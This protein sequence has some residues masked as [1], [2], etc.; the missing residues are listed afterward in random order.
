M[1]KRANG[2]GTKIT[3][4]ENGKW[5]QRVTLS[6]GTRKAFYGETQAEVRQKRDEF[7]DAFRAGRISTDAAQ[8]VGKYLRDWLKTHKRIKRSTRDDY[9][10]QIT[11]SESI[12]KVRLDQVKPAHLQALYDELEE[13]GLSASSIDHVH[14]VLRIAFRRAVKLG[15]IL[16]PPTEIATPPR[17]QSVERPTLSAEQAR[18]LLTSDPQHRL[19]AL[20][21]LFL[22]QGLRSGEALGLRWS[23][24]DF[25]A[26]RVSIRHTIK[27]LKG[28]GLVPETPKT[29][30]SRRTLTLLPATSAVLRARRIRQAEEQLKA[31]Q[32]ESS[33]EWADLVF[34]T[35]T[36]RPLDSSDIGRVLHRALRNAGLPLIRVHDLRHT[37]A[38]LLC[39]DGCDL[40]HVQR[41]LGHSSYHL[42]ADTYTH[43]R[44]EQGPVTA[45]LERLFPVIEGAIS[46]SR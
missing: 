25:D 32:W 28:I 16:R 43:V 45:H 1:T 21:V 40:I 14:R 12:H 20:W 33:P 36:G 41:A 37:Y 27:R 42:T 11:L 30:S 26:G 4:H 44:P 46:T 17:S 29:P 7:L 22:L 15:Y 6:E 18:T 39:E 31:E 10:R 23:D 8:P 9:D 24:I 35:E 5:W 38:T 3:R 34:T 2:D 19:H 13:R